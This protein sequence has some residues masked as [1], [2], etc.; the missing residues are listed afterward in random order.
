LFASEYSTMSGTSVERHSLTLLERPLA[1]QKLTRYLSEKVS[2]TGSDSW[3]STFSSSL[4]T[5]ACWRR[6]TD[7][8][9]MSPVQPNLT[10]SFVHSM[11][12]G[13][14]MSVVVNV[15]ARIWG[16]YQSDGGGVIGVGNAKVLLVNV[17]QL[18]VVLADSVAL[19]ALE[20]E[21]DDIRRVLGLEGQDVL[22]LSGTENL[23]QR[24]EVDAEGDVAVAAE[25]RE[26]VGLEQHGDEGDV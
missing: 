13:Q 15:I 3:I 6:V 16:T 26:G 7:P 9:P 4:S 17:H 21:V 12:T 8:E 18:D 20:D 22:V 23:L 1:L 10:P 2:D 5:L 14:A 19:G 11:L 25:G 24:D